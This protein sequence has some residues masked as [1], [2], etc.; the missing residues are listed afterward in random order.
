M[1]L[2]TI[3]KQRK[4]SVPKLAELSGVPRRTIQEIENRD[5]CRV[6]TAIKLADALG[7]TLDELCRDDINRPPET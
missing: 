3:R 1:R 5:D 7:V 2:K 4:L 6:S